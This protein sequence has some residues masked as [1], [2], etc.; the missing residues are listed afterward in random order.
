MFI[1]L[2]VHSTILQCLCNELEWIDNKLSKGCIELWF[3]NAGKGD[4][5]TPIGDDD[6]D[7]VS[8]NHGELKSSDTMYVPSNLSY[9]RD[10]RASFVIPKSVSPI[11]L[12]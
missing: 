1:Q 6:A 9:W 7:A 10:V 11:L 12:D 4:A 5:S 2:W 8:Q 3:P